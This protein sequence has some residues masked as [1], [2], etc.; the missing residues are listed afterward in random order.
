MF[1]RSVRTHR[2]CPHLPTQSD[3]GSQ[4]A[5]TWGRNSA[6]SCNVIRSLHH[7]TG[8]AVRTADVRSDRRVRPFRRP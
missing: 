2:D 5:R 3:L 6:L 8:F 4:T 1:A 7:N